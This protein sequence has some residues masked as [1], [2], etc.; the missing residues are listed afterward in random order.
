MVGIGIRFAAHPLPGA[1]IEDT[2]L[3][4]SEAGMVNDDLR[5]LSMLVTWFGVHAPWVNADRLV[6]IV[7]DHRSPRVRTLWSALASWQARDRRF[8]R[9]VPSHQG[10]RIDLLRVGTDF[11]LHRHGE[12]ERFKGTP[13]RVP[14][15][16]LRNRAV[17]I[18][19]P[20]EL[21]Q[22]HLAF[23][24]RV[25]MG[26]TYRADMWAALTQDPSLSAAEIAR[27]AYGSFAT[28]WQVRRDFFLVHGEGT[29]SL[30]PAPVHDHRS[31]QSRESRE[32]QG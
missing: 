10:P 11:Q 18:A 16:V 21:C 25:M 2:L 3:F 17:D 28:A 19:S 8:S 27:R 20:T 26:P 1:N 14:A 31:M 12:D 7:R 6:R 22:R 29:D 30:T 23:R 32:I 15:G 5:V 4:A 9:L 24:H 13:L